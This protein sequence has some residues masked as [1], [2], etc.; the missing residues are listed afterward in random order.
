MS[1]FL[2]FHQGS[3]AEEKSRVTVMNARIQTELEHLKTISE[4]EKS[5]T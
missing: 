1:V 3:V 2:I 4:K 5:A